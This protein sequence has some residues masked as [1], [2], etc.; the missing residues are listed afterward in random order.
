MGKRMHDY[1]DLKLLNVLYADDDEQ[2][3]SSTEKTLKLI[4]SKVISVANGAQALEKYRDERIDI[5]I[6]DVRMGDFSG[7]DVAQEIRKSNKEIP[8]IIISSYTETEDL[9]AACKLNLI[10][11]LRKP[12]EFKQLID[13]LFSALIQLKEKGLLVRKILDNVTYNYLSK[14]LIRDDVAIPLTKNEILVMELLLSQRGRLI[15]YDS[16]FYVLEEE[17]SDGALKNLILRLRKKIGEEKT[18]RNLS[19]IGYTLV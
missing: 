12:V 2:L 5:V 18:I 9:L 1:E 14:N 10:D 6:L 15:T 8:I 3:R 19:K 17:M 4:V 16:F 11:Y 7:I 13:A